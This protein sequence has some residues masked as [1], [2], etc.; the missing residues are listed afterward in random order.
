MTTTA[1]QADSNDWLAC[2]RKKKE[3]G[4]KHTGHSLES[5]VTRPA[6]QNK[7]TMARLIHDGADDTTGAKLHGAATLLQLLPASTVRKRKKGRRGPSFQNPPLAFFLFL[8][9]G[10]GVLG[11]HTTLTPNNP[12]PPVSVPGRFDG[13]I[14][15]FPRGEAETGCH[16]MSLGR[17]VSGKRG[18]VGPLHPVRNLSS[19]TPAITDIMTS[20][21]MR[22][23][24]GNGIRGSR[25]LS[26]FFFITTFCVFASIS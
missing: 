3:A 7:S 8:L 5:R 4:G 23:L 25:L 24:G 11:G 18:S 9:T 2:T 19:A 22:D 17:G 13:G 14:F 15:L 6:K 26:H 21:I 1:M 16:D 10:L 20:F 12:S